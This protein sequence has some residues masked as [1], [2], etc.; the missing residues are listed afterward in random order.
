MEEVASL[1]DS[2]G[3]DIVDRLIL[4]PVSLF[5]VLFAL[6]IFYAAAM[7]MLLYSL[8]RSDLQRVLRLGD[9]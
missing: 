9:E 2:L 6:F 8:S 5:S 4:N 7:L 3:G 1:A